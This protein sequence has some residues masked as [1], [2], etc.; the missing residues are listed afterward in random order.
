MYIVSGYIREN[1]GKIL[2]DLIK[3]GISENIYFLPYGHKTR[4][5]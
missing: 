5:I 4:K 1:K 2:C 3:A